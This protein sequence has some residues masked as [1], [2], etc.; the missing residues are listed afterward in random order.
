[1]RCC[2]C[3]LMFGDVVRVFRSRCRM[4]PVRRVAQVVFVG[5]VLK[6]SAKQS[7]RPL[8][9]LTKNAVSTAG[10]CLAPLLA[11]SFICST[12]LPLNRLPRVRSALHC[13]ALNH[14]TSHFIVAFLLCVILLEAIY[15]P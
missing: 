7:G 10:W 3:F 14:L 9:Y 5:G 12:L 4:I 8:V 2:L 1:M 15:L 11:P 13:A 6:E